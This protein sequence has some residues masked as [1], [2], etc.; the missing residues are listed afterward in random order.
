MEHRSCVQCDVVQTPAEIADAAGHLECAR[1]VRR[2]QFLREISR[3][4]LGEHQNEV[5]ALCTSTTE[6]NWLH[7]AAKP[8]VF[9]FEP[10]AVDLTVPTPWTACLALGKRLMVGM[11]ANQDV[12]AGKRWLRR[13]LVGLFSSDPLEYVS[14]E[15]MSMV[16]EY[17]AEDPYFKHH[18]E[19]Y[20]ARNEAREVLSRK[21]EQQVVWRQER[22]RDRF[23]LM[24]LKR[25]QLREKEIARCAGK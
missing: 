17:F 19:A 22:E 10:W 21:K 9:M 4:A 25:K 23:G 13:G 5:L 12:E 1:I 15:H 8:G 2:Y 18:L 3:I 24:E 7:H 11:G 14:P 6:R 20:K 16:R